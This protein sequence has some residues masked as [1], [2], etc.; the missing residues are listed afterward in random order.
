MLSTDDMSDPEIL[1][2]E[3]KGPAPAT[4][5]TG[6]ER[7]IR[8]VQKALPGQAVRVDVAPATPGSPLPPR[9]RLEAAGDGGEIVVES[10]PLMTALVS[11][12]GA[13]FSYFLS[14]DIE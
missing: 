9:F 7:L 10:G 12:R 11:F 4:T 2:P 14:G 6:I 8:E 5:A 1:D 13:R 3:G